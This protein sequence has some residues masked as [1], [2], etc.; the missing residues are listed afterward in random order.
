MLLKIVEWAGLPT[1]QEAPKSDEERLG[2]MTQADVV[3]LSDD[4]LH[5]KLMAQLKKDCP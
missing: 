2:Q 1:P 5:E 3:K 4:D